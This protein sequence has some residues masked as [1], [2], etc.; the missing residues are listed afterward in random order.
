MT[1]GVPYEGATHTVRAVHRVH[2]GM[3]V[4]LHP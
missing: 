3:C 2:Q 1:L 4:W